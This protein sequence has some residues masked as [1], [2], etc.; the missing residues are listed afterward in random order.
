MSF[1][2]EEKYTTLPA[3]I[4]YLEIDKYGTMQNETSHFS[5]LESSIMNYRTDFSIGYPLYHRMI[6]PNIMAMSIVML[7]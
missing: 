1:E 4:N 2:G 3:D 6:F 7:Q 5:L